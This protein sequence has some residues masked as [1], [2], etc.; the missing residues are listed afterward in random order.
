MQIQIKEVRIVLV[1]EVVCTTKKLSVRRV[2]QVYE[3][4]E[5]T[6]C[7]CMK[8]YL[9]KA[10]KRNVQYILI[11]SE[12]EMFV[13]YV[14]DLDSRRFSPRLSVVRS[15]ADLL[16]TIYRMISI[17]KQWL[18]NFIRC[19]PEFKTRFS[20]VYDF[21]RAL[22]ENPAVLNV[23]FRL[24]ANIYAKYTIQ[25]KDFYNFDEIGFVEQSARRKVY[26]LAGC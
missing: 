9:P 8:G 12:E 13:R 18:Y 2:A 4:F 3:F 15:M 10:E 5:S 16:R 22:Y 21:Q 7:N 19:C 17:G 24:V 11:E 26:V 25:E 14:F 20:R 23:W 1:I 6:I